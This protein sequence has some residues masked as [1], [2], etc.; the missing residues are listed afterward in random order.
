MR[1]LRLVSG[2]PG[3]GKSTVS[4]LLAGRHARGV[5]L[6]ADD[7]WRYVVSG[8]VEPWL[9]GS[10]AQNAVVMSAVV[11]AAVRFSTGGY[12]T[13]VDAVIGP[14]FLDAVVRTAREEGLAL[15]Y[16]VLRP[17]QDVAVQRAAARGEAGLQD[18]AAV[19]LMHVQ[20]E[21]LGPFERHVLDTSRLSPAET[22]EAIE[23]SLAEG[24]FA[25]GG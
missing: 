17:S 20:F 7:F 15:D 2:P 8:S 9:P 22:A 16:V 3:A 13:F 14:W 12:E 24:T 10:A 5:H 21:D 25:V 19:R 4:R 18:E 23:R 1:A 6:H 11:A